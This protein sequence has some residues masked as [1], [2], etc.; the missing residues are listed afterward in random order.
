MR[1]VRSELAVKL[2]P[3]RSVWPISTGTGI[4][5]QIQ[6]KADPEVCCE[7]LRSNYWSLDFQR[8][9]LRNESAKALTFFV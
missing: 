6:T 4:P 2:P 1:K 7:D 9:F 3:P 5:E 8:D